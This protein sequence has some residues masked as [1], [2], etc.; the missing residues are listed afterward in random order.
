MAPEQL[1]GH[2]RDYGPWTDLYAL[3]IVAWELAT[4]IV[5]FD[6]TSLIEIGMSHL[7]DPLPPLRPRLPIPDQLEGWL[8]KMTAK[9][10]ADRF[11]CAAD[12]AAALRSMPEPDPLA[13]PIGTFQAGPT[14]PDEQPTQEFSPANRTTSESASVPLLAEGTRIRRDDRF[15][16]ALPPMPATWRANHDVDVPMPV[17]GA[18]LGL[19]NLRVPGYV[20]RAERRDELWE[21]LRAARA[22]GHPNMVLIRGVA[23]VG[24]SALARWFC[25]RVHEL[26][27]ATVL[28]AGHT[29]GMHR[30]EGLPSMLNY[31]MRVRDLPSEDLQKR[32]S[33]EMKRLGIT[34][35]EVVRGIAD[36]VAPAAGV[37]DDELRH[38]G[39]ARDRWSIARAVLEAMGH[40]R[41]VVIWFDDVQWGADS[42]AFV[43]HVLATADENDDLPLV[44]VMTARDEA[45][46]T[47]EAEPARVLLDVLMGRDD[48][49][50]FPLQPLPPSEC[51]TLIDELLVL[52]E[53]LAARVV[54]RSGGNPLFAT[55]IVREWVAKGVLDT[56]PVGFRLRDGADEGIPDDMYETWRARVEAVARR[57]GRDA[58]RALQIAA[59]LEGVIDENEWV[60]AA[61]QLGISIPTG[62]VDDL[63]RARLVES[64]EGG[65]EFAHGM[66]R[67]S[68][69]RSAEDSGHAAEIHRAIALMLVERYAHG[70]PGVSERKARH[71]LD[72]DELDAAIDALLDGA[73]ERFEGGDFARADG[74]LLQREETLARLRPERTDPRWAEGR[75]WLADTALRR[76][77]ATRAVTWAESAAEVAEA[78]QTRRLQIRALD[79][80]GAAIRRVGDAERARVEGEAAVALAREDGDNLLIGQTLLNL[81]HSQIAAGDALAAIARF[82]EAREAFDR[83]GDAGKR[84]RAWLAQA[85]AL[86]AR[87]MHEEAQIARAHAADDGRAAEDHWLVERARNLALAS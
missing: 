20:G 48:A 38:F 5:P 83:A 60:D 81:G 52:D 45:L 30:R 61:A 87:G 68:I 77:D 9:R 65:W 50:C 3:G 74:L 63:A 1:T 4:G 21:A 64:S 46:A 78:S 39:R 2:W 56:T 36:L 17:V 7:H 18:G 86:D 15:R 53:A 23:G 26:G 35:P 31:L 79:T 76:G 13:L 85:M 80:L 47:D 28:K 57:R 84:G 66:I 22:T 69:A 27:V 75:V 55:H 34:T 82:G 73:V 71:L 42:V 70:S 6:G 32:V 12:A 19:M 40:E 44:F 49:M 10:F 59:L 24:K 54:A 14:L 11:A 43:Q 29:V 58:Q 62:L 72:A 67:E 33:R 51:R 8:E 37:P 16:I 41:P 25:D